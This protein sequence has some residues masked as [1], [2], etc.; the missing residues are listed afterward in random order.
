MAE[1]KNYC[2]QDTYMH[3]NKCYLRHLYQSKKSYI[4]TQLESNN[5]NSQM[6]FQILH[7][8]TKGQHDNPLPDCSSHE[9]LAN[10]F[11]DFFINKIEKIR[12]QF[13]QS[14][15]YT[16]PSQK[17]KNF[18]QFRPISDEETLKILNNMKKTTC[19]VDPCNIN[20]LMEFKGTLLGTWT[21]IINKSLLNGCFLQSWKK[22]IIRPL[23]KS[24]KL[25]REFKNCQP[26]SNLSFISKSIEKAALLQLS[27]FFEDQNL[28]PTYQSAYHK[29]HSTEMG[30]LNIC[31]E[32]LENA[33]HNKLTAM[34]CLD[35]SAAFDTVNHSILKSVMEHYFGLK[36]TT[37]KWLSSYITNRQFSVKIGG[38]FLH[39][40][41]INFSVPQ[42]SILDPVLFSC[43]VSTLPEVTKQNSDSIILS[44]A[45]DHA[46]THAFTQKDTLVKQIVEEK[47]NRIK[48][49]MCMNHLQ[50]IDTKTEFIH[51]WHNSPA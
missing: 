1:I 8:L 12:S 26:I 22:A 36:D 39:A 45:D 20:F 16:P 2:R 5:N 49:W 47:V 27:T 31:D 6:L 37:L 24:S 28:Q 21:K 23:I 30:V 43:Y 33:E 3:I 41:T 29:H 51:L 32:I 44:Y 38:S 18:T 17:C 25:H 4:N 34:V 10:N 9:E 48:N 11:A 40:H 46:F 19:D 50:M 15:L 7:Q 42:G 35:L 14:R 13:Q